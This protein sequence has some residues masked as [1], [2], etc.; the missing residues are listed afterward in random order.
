M[1]KCPECNAKLTIAQDIEQWDRIR[2][3]RCGAELEVLDVRP[4]ELEAVSEI[5][6]SGSADD[7]DWEDEDEEETEEEIE[8][9]D[10]TL[11][12]EDWN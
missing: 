6:P 8:F 12:D 2:C 4:L 3:D 1:A 7:L 9:E 11:D 10:M 5:R